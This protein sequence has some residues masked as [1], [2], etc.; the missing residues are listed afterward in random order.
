M[1]DNMF[2]TDLKKDKRN[3]T[4][5]VSKVSKKNIEILV[6]ECRSEAARGDCQNY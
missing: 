3:E 5:K 2:Y 4:I 6:E 1:L